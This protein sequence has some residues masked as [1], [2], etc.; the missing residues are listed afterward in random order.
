[1]RIEI[2][3]T[4]T[5][6]LSG[7][8]YTTKEDIKNVFCCKDL[9]EAY[10]DNKVVIQYGQIGVTGTWSDGDLETEIS[11]CP[12]CGKKI[13]IVEVE[14]EKKVAYTVKEKK[15]VEVTKYKVVEE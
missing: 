12:F 13:E 1:M 4:E 9:E 14:R 7:K 2:K 10:N 5:T 11:Y 3:V 6:E 8:T 15:E